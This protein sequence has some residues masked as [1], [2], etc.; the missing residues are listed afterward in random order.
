M[1][2]HYGFDLR[3]SN[4]Q[5]LLVCTKSLNSSVYFK[6]TAQLNLDWSHFECLIASSSIGK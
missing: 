4:A 3:F 6:G 1:A 2:S 5:C